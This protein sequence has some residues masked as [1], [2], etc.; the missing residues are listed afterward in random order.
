ML[1]FNV[2]LHISKERTE[3]KNGNRKGRVLL[4]VVIPSIP[5]YLRAC[6]VEGEGAV[7]MDLV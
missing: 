6:G 4:L 1:Y 3:L 7:V 2:A 5:A